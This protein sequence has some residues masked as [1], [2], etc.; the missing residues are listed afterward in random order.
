MSSR[1]RKINRLVELFLTLG[2]MMHPKQ[3]ETVFALP[4][5]ERCE[6]FVKVVADRQKAWG[7]YDDGWAMAAADDGT[8]VLPLWPH[9]E[10][11]KAC[12]VRRWAGYEPHSPLANG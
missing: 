1:T 12:A 2:T 6:H 5:S 3:L 7:L 4:S 9:R 11:A 8:F 10:Y